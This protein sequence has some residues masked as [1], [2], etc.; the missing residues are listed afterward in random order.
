M[1]IYPSEPH[2]NQNILE[3]KVDKIS[4]TLQNFVDDQIFASSLLFICMFISIILSNIDSISDTY[5][6]MI[7]I[8]FGLFF[9]GYFVNTTVHDFVNDFLLTLFFFVLGLE[10]KR[11]F[12]IGELSELS[13]SL[14]IILCSL[15]GAILPI[16]TYLCIN[17]TNP[18]T[19]HGWAI[20]MA[21]DTALAIGVLYLYKS[22]VSRK[23]FTLIA[24][25]AVIDDI[26][27]IVIIA[28][29]YSSHFNLMP[30]IFSLSIFL[31]LI[32]MNLSGFRH[33]LIYAFFGFLMWF[34]IEEAG[35]HGTI[36]GILTA[37][38]IPARPQKKPATAVKKI[39]RLLT[40]FEDE[41][42]EEKH[43]LK[44]EKP[45]QLLEGV[46][47]VSLEATT[48]LKRWE[49]R[50]EFPVLVLV[51]PLFALTNGGFNIDFSHISLSLKETLFWG[52]F[53]GLVFAK[54]IGILLTSWIIQKFKIAK[55]PSG[56]GLYDMV[57]IA[58]LAGI[59]YTMSI[60]ISDLSFND[61]KTVDIAKLSIFMGSIVSGFI[62]ILVLSKKKPIKTAC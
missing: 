55:S 3:K 2:A 53:I 60:F 51:L 11:E 25:L 43:L 59:G 45:H 7:N 62:A 56:I 39:R 34:F 26:F 18:D 24:S 5:H 13:K 23:A 16:I 28:L 9:N 52:I 54:P 4:S 46:R 21:T 27:S 35:I 61:Q 29:F 37:M 15:G 10:I 41:Y 20:P 30:L 19:I 36:A 22:K 14:Y 32:T 48:P 49:N 1:S 44:E 33:P 31:L 6:K 47:D 17:Y 12:V 8:P 40:L 50:L 38:C 57:V 58:F 42:D